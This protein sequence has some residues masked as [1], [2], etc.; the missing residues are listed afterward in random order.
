MLANDGHGVPDM[1]ITKFGSGI[2]RGSW[3]YENVEPFGCGINAW[4][5][6]ATP[7]GN[8][9][10][11]SFDGNHGSGSSNPDEYELGNDLS[12]VV[13]RIALSELI[14]LGGVRG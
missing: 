7:N 13:F 14:T 11:D 3:M 8:G 10:G 4:C 1:P 12:R 9:W 5:P 2:G 6:D